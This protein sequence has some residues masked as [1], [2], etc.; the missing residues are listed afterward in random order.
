M[1]GGLGGFGHLSKIAKVRV[2]AFVTFKVM[3]GLSYA[4]K[5]S[6]PVVQLFP[7]PDRVNLYPSDHHP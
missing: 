3:A 5:R 6:P 7:R 1:G 4:D 2:R